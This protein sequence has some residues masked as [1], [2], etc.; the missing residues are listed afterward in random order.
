MNHIFKKIAKYEWKYQNK[1]P[2]KLTSKKEVRLI[3]KMA[4]I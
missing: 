4:S 1:D 3:L 2:I